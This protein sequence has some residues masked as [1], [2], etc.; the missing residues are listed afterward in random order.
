MQR[1]V[2]PSERAVE[3]K[4]PTASALRSARQDFD[5]GV[6]YAKLMASSV[7]AD[8]K[9]SFARSIVYRITRAYWRTVVARK[10]WPLAFTKQTAQCRIRW[11]TVR[12]R[13]VE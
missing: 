12:N 5:Y 11:R 3:T 2:V 7:D 1:L 9:L 8:V 6:S 10:G 4:P 13:R